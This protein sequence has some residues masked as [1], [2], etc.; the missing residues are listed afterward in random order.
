[1]SICN[2]SGC[3]KE[4]K[5]NR[6]ICNT[7][8]WRKRVHGSYDVPKKKVLVKYNCKVP[9]CDN[10]GRVRTGI[11]GLHY[12]RMYENGS[13][14]LPERN[15]KSNR[16]PFSCL[17]CGKRYTDFRSRYSQKPLKYCSRQC[18]TIHGHSVKIEKICQKCNTSYAISQRNS[19]RCKGCPKCKERYRKAKVPTRCAT[20]TKET[21]S[22]KSKKWGCSFCSKKCAGAYRTI[23]IFPTGYRKIKIQHCV[24]N[25]IEIQCERCKIKDIDML[26]IHHVDHLRR[27]NN[28]EN[29]MILCG[30]CHLKEHR[31]DTTVLKDYIQLVQD[32]KNA[33][34]IG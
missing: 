9:G 5:E 6:K 13:Y 24:I 19:K 18:G 21:W 27:N 11:C 16:N 33:F 8:R 14:Q 7:H 22:R 29:L 20:C 34:K 4:T 28:I 23:N 10:L 26:V 3:T 2:I 32:A 15:I 31:K 25:D 17:N 30:N 12:S 1:M